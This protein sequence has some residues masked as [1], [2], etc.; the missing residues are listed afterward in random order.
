MF[1]TK[2]IIILVG[3]VFLILGGTLLTRKLNLEK[4]SK[5]FML[6]GV[7]SE[8]VKIFSYIIK[9]EAAY[10][11][12]LPKSD[13]PF[14]LCSI[15]IIFI[16]VVVFSHNEKIKRIL[17]SFMMPSGLIGGGAA[18]LIPTDSSLSIWSITLQYNLYHCALIVFAIDLLLDKEMDF[19]IKDYY[20]CL[21][22]I[23]ALLF[24]SVYI[25]S[26]VYDAGGITNAN[27]MYVVSPPKE[28]LPFLNENHGWL[29]YII[30]YAMLVLFAITICYI[31][32][33][34]TA[35]KTRLTKK[36]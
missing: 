25:N 5:A 32:P 10:G 29:I 2:H 35:L 11:G 34:Y 16:M 15:Q 13:L 36:Q 18:L 33:I 21:I 7:C 26:I 20:S 14:H 9:N 30:H 8:V 27:F 31:K 24:F 12:V 1:G 22:F 23:F 6:V 19:S 4:R 28:G 17:L 3:C